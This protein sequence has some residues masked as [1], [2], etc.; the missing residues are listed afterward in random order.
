M[1]K[2]KCYGCGATVD[3]T[4]EITHKY[5][6]AVPGCWQVYTHILAKEYGEYGYPELVHRLTVDT[7][8]IQHPE[9][10]GQRSKQAIQ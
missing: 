7:Y 2:I 4:N 9:H 3:D 10:P 5:I 8:A 1:K 6:G